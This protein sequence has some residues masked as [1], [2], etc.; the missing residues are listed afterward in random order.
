MDFFL[1]QK[2]RLTRQLLFWA[3]VWL[4]YIYFFSYGTTNFRYVMILS[5]ALLPITLLTSQIVSRHLIPNLL[6]KNQLLKFGVFLLAALLFTAIYILLVLIL[7]VGFI[8]NLRAEDI[9][10]MGRNY[11]FILALVFLIV[12]MVSLVWLWKFYIEKESKTQRSLLAS[13]VQFK[14]QEMSFLKSQIHPHFLFNGLNTIYGFALKES[15]RTPEII[16]TLTK[17]LDYILYQ[18]DKPKVLLRDEIGHIQDYIAM[19]EIRFHDSLEVIMEFEIKDKSIEIAPLVL[20]PFIENAFKHGA[21]VDGKLKVEI[22]LFAAQKRLQFSIKNTGGSIAFE[23]GVGLSNIKK[24]LTLLY[25][26]SHNLV[27]EAKNN[28]FTVSLNIELQTL[29]DGK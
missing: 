27:I 13:K 11:T 18:V 7:G 6:L 19:E 26:E 23:D 14:E 2:F 9:P 8:P 1:N 5:A 22:A 21:P 15:K 3:G 28:H 12:L 29:I 10:P 24:R 25:P 4:F 17:L 16:L 20:L